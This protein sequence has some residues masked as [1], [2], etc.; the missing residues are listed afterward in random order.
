LPSAEAPPR[1]IGAGS[2]FTLNVLCEAWS[3]PEYGTPLSLSLEKQKDK[4]K[5]IWHVIEKR[6]AGSAAGKGRN[7]F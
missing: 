5:R 6:F 7:C 4:E 2:A 3:P 1:L